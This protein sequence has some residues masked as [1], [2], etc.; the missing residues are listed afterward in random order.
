MFSLV[1]A[2]SEV[3]TRDPKNQ[4]PGY[5]RLRRVTFR[6]RFAG[7]RTSNGTR[8]FGLCPLKSMQTNTLSYWENAVR[9]LDL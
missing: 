6:L 3:P 8:M 7:V 2:A 5:R 4:E 1:V 9:C